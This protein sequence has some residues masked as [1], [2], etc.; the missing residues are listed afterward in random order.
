[1]QTTITITELTTQYVEAMQEV[2]A[3]DYQTYV[4]NKKLPIYEIESITH[5]IDYLDVLSNL[6]IQLTD[7]TSV[8][9]SDVITR[10]QFVFNRTMKILQVSMDFLE[11]TGEELAR[12][13]VLV[14]AFCK[15][16]FESEPQYNPAGILY[17]C[18]LL[19]NWILTFRLLADELHFKE[20]MEDQITILKGE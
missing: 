14:Q 5:P 15:S 6:S 4:V 3:K 17:S 20:E 11:H 2:A 8:A 7:K 10:D 1:M 18:L 16:T 12:N 19:N 9:F 13:L